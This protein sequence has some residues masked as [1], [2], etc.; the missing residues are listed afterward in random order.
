MRSGDPVGRSPYRRWPSGLCPLPLGAGA[1]PLFKVEMGIDTQV[2]Q[3]LEGFVIA[4][5]MIGDEDRV[6]WIY[7]GGSHYFF[8]LSDLAGDPRE[9]EWW[10]KNIYLV[11]AKNLREMIESLA[12]TEA[13]PWATE[14]I[15]ADIVGRG[16]ATREE[17]G[18]DIPL[19]RTREIIAKYTEEVEIAVR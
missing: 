13:E 2:G 15:L 11:P 3:V 17:I 6:F 5:E 4:P 10:Q 1:R 12:K 7:P 19:P 9:T 18:R 8:R 16:Y 14:L